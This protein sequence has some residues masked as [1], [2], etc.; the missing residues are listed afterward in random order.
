MLV[1]RETSLG[2]LQH[3]VWFLY[4]FVWFCPFCP[5]FQSLYHIFSP[6]LQFGRPQMDFRHGI[7]GA[8]VLQWTGY[9]ARQGQVPERNTYQGRKHIKHIKHI[10]TALDYLDIF[11]SVFFGFWWKTIVGSPAFADP[12]VERQ[13]VLDDVVHRCR[14]HRSRHL[15][16]TGRGN[17][18][19]SLLGG[20]FSVAKSLEPWLP[21]IQ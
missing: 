12:S 7:R 1:F 13:S 11:R 20:L 16:T 15:A 9:R 10:Y 18:L 14:H 17:L 21:F 19:L 2:A 4:D 5:F 3:F 6:S 8:G